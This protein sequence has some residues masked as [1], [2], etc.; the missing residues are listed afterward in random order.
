[1]VEIHEYDDKRSITVANIAGQDWFCRYP[2]PTQVTFD[3]GV[4]EFIGKDFQKMF[5]EDYGMPNL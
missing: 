2:W 5:K 3:K 4:S 1:M